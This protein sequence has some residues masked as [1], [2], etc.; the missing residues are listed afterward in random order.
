[1]VCFPWYVFNM[2]LPT[3]KN[4]AISPAPGNAELTAKKAGNV[5]PSVKGRC[6]P[7]LFPKMKGKEGVKG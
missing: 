5:P 1:M 4:A 6:F 7:Y 3:V 2:W